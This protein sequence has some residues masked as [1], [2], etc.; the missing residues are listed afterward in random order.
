MFQPSLFEHP[1][2]ELGYAFVCSSRLLF[3]TL[4]RLCYAGPGYLFN[5]DNFISQKSQ[6]IEHGRRLRRTIL[7]FA[8]SSLD[9]DLSR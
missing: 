5:F 6:R 1:H 2:H 4:P 7:S 8:S 3:N 9:L